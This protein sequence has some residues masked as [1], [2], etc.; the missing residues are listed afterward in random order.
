VIK[1][2]EIIQYLIDLERNIFLKKGG[3]TTVDRK[4]VMICFEKCLYS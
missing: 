2:E 1:K 4:A 3:G